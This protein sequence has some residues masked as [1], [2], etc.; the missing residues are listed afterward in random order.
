MTDLCWYWLAPG[1]GKTRVLTHRVGHM[2]LDL[3]VA[4]W[5]ILAVTFTNKAAREMKERLL[6][7]EILTESQLHALSA[8]TFHGICARILRQEIE[9]LGV[10]SRDFVIFDSG[11]QISIIKEIL[12]AEN[13]SPDRFSPRGVQAGISKAKNDLLT[14][15][16]FRPAT[17]REEIIKRVYEI[18]QETLKENNALDFDDLIMITHQLFSQ[19][20]AILAKYQERYVH[21]MVDEFQDTNLAQYDLVKLLAG[22]HRNLFAVGDEDQS[23]YSWRG[24]DY[25]NV[26]RF[27][28]DFPDA[29]LILLERNYRS[30]ETILKAAGAIIDRNR[31]RHAKTLFT[32]RGEGP[33]IIRIETYDGFDEARYVINEIQRMA[34]YDDV[35]PSDVAVMYRT[36]AQSRVIEEAFIRANM[37]YRLV[38]GTR[39]YERKEVKDA[40]AYLRLIHNPHDTLSLRRV[41]NVPGRGIGAKTIERLLDWAVESGFSPWQALVQL[42]NLEEDLDLSQVPQKVSKAHPFA[43]KATNSLVH[44]TKI[45][46][47]LIAAKE[48]MPLTDLIDLMLART[49]Y[50]EFLQDGTDEGEERWENLQELKTVARSYASFENNEALALFL[51][52][53]AL[54]SD[55]D[56]LKDHDHGPAL[57][58]MHAAKGLEFPI[59]F[60]VGM[61]DGIFPHSRSREDPEQMEE[62]RRLAYVGVTRAKDQL[63]LLHAFRRMIFGTD[64][65][66][67]PSPFLSD[68]PPELV[69]IRDNKGSALSSGGS[70]SWQKTAVTSQSSYRSQTRWERQRPSKRQDRSRQDK[71]ATATNGAFKTGDRVGHTKFGEGTVIGTEMDGR[72]EMVTVAFPGKGIKKLMAD[73]AGLEKL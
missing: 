22:G 70:Q 15:E 2:I 73:I 20:E 62:E 1:S 55:V 37:P 31:H 4:P 8:G 34:A 25:R 43:R 21:V 45:M 40:L 44:F 41:I 56:G 57:L 17:Y 38:R 46:M 5:R 64:E 30:T 60:M 66:A 61:E 52:E 16:K 6:N 10:Y 72:D 28:E 33:A 11:D 42:H 24:A 9:H 63:Y 12:K 49:G 68:I 29:K 39:F 23:I 3:D 32:E 26:L 71:A 19:Q 36:N 7:Q 27:K 53:I 59:V 47:L 48:K 35:S 50:R 65:L 18:Y 69:E 54:I 13:I 51:E 58:T 67:K 14:P